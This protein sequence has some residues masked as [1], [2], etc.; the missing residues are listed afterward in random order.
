MSESKSTHK[1]LSKTPQ[2]KKSHDKEKGKPLPSIS[3]TNDGVNT[4]KRSSRKT[5]E[6]LPPSNS[7][8]R[9]K[10][11]H[12]GHPETSAPWEAKNSGS[13][14]ER[15]NHSRQTKRPAS[16]TAQPISK[17][18]ASIVDTCEDYEPAYSSSLSQAPV[19]VPTMIT[20]DPITVTL[21]S[22]D[23]FAE[24]ISYPNYAQPPYA[25]DTFGSIPLREPSTSLPTSQ[26]ASGTESLQLPGI[27]KEIIDGVISHLS[28]LPMFHNLLSS[29]SSVPQNT[30]ENVRENLFNDTWQG[31][32]SIQSNTEGSGV[33]PS[34][35]ED[36]GNT[37]YDTETS[38][39]ND[40]GH[41]NTAEYTHAPTAESHEHPLHKKAAELLDELLACGPS[42]WE[43]MH[44]AKLEAHNH[45]LRYYLG[46]SIT[47]ELWKGIPHLTTKGEFFQTLTL[48]VDQ[49]IVKINLDK[50]RVPYFQI[51]TENSGCNIHPLFR[52]FIC[53]GSYMQTSQ[54]VNPTSNREVFNKIAGIFTNSLRKETNLYPGTETHKGL[55]MI[56]SNNDIKEILQQVENKVKKQESFSRPTEIFNLISE[57]KEL[58][59][60]LNSSILPTNPSSREHRELFSLLRT[61]EEPR[62]LRDELEFRKTTRL[63]WQNLELID[64]TVKSL[65]AYSKL[66]ESFVTS[67]PASLPPMHKNLK[68]LGEFLALS[69]NSLI[70]FLK[71]QAKLAI[72]KKLEIRKFML[73]RME[74]V[75]IRNLLLNDSVLNEGLFTEATLQES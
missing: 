32:L 37:S 12:R 19:Y 7:S 62:S 64:F 66:Q 60:Y 49:R 25:H 21:T 18:M 46:R 45:D 52:P 5:K 41:I 30:A 68:N 39:T 50:E 69:R 31:D 33:Y 20:P 10:E 72:R 47:Y 38:S 14:I 44:N 54:T 63:L 51:T 56:S 65:D 16:P 43:P 75:T 4:P 48:P 8:F 35:A 42:S 17:R 53:K 11:H 55:Q 2:A 15:E 71:D 1:D 22:V 57:N 40:T 6:V 28:G 3:S 74:P 26:T 73:G 27:S 70:S 23:P 29:H 13:V 36:M 9:A 58:S 59:D 24:E 67:G 34:A 61:N